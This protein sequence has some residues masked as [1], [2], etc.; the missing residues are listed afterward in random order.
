MRRTF[1]VR[2]SHFTCTLSSGQAPDDHAKTQ[3]EC[4]SVRI[5]RP[6]SHSLIWGH[7]RNLR[8][9]EAAGRLRTRT[10]C[11]LRQFSDLPHPRKRHLRT[12]RDDFSACANTPLRLVSRFSALHAKPL[13]TVLTVTMEAC[14][15]NLVNSTL[16]VIPRQKVMRR[17]YDAG[18]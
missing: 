11:L 18:I 2:S 3:L 7:L 5:S 4:S 6:L 17:V 13:L 14:H 1:G 8:I 16:H 15:L 12:I 10:S 9:Q